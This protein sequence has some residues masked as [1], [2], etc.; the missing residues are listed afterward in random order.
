MKFLSVIDSENIQGVAGTDAEDFVFSVFGSGFEDPFNKPPSRSA[1]LRSKRK[2]I[3]KSRKKLQAMKR[4]TNRKAKP[5]SFLGSLFN[6]KTNVTKRELNRGIEAIVRKQP[7]HL[8]ATTRFRLKNLAKQQRLNDRQRSMSGSASRA[9]FLY[10]INSQEAR[11]M[12]GIYS[13]VFDTAIRR[14]AKDQGQDLRKILRGSRGKNPKYKAG[15]GGGGVWTIRKRAIKGYDRNGKPCYKYEPT[16]II[17][18]ADDVGFVEQVLEGDDG[19][20]SADGDGGD[21]GKGIGA[22]GSDGGGT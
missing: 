13:R 18:P 1:Y 6:V 10:D 20:T 7:K 19:G 12:T 15:I 11:H 17:L 16:K 4:R 22:G 9:N 8:R 21:G 5:R 14:G 3:R 2:A